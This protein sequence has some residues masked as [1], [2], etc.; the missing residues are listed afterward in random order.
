MKL[1]PKI[2]RLSEHH[3]TEAKAEQQKT[4]TSQLRFLSLEEY[5]S[6]YWNGP[7]TVVVKTATRS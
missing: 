5:D 2:K 1:N 4:Q 6:K 3:L 7:K